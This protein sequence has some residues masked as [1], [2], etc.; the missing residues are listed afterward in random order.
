MKKKIN[1]LGAEE[2]KQALN[3]LQNCLTPEGLN[4]IIFSKEKTRYET[5]R[6]ISFCVWVD[7]NQYKQLKEY[8]QAADAFKNDELEFSEENPDAEPTHTKIEL[9]ENVKDYLEHQCAICFAIANH[10]DCEK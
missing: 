10:E 9:P 6:E 5:R 7:K 4:R 2:S 1:V 3:M 8:A